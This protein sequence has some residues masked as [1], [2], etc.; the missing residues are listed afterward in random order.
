MFR[1][2]FFW[3]S[4][5]TKF[6]DVNDLS[7]PRNHWHQ[8]LYFSNEFFIG[9]GRKLEW[10]NN[11][12]DKCECF[13]I[14]RRAQKCKSARVWEVFSPRDPLNGR[15][16]LAD[17]LRSNFFH[18]GPSLSPFGSLLRNGEAPDEPRCLSSNRQS[19]GSD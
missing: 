1:L 10:Q 7:L 5:E 17:N 6:E 11:Q 2:I 9:L 18:P 12:Y 4:N 8:V 15:P 14:F 16:S 3:L 19:N 13:R